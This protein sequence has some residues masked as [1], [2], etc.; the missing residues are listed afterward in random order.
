MDRIQTIVA[1][2]DFSEPSAAAL[3]QADRLSRQTR[4][5]LHVVHVIEELSH[6]ELYEEF[7]L[8]VSR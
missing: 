1:A 8:E 7:G 6:A 3:V 5:K 2:V 4:A